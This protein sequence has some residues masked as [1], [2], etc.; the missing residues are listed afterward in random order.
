[1]R[2]MMMTINLRF[3]RERI[4]YRSNVIRVYVIVVM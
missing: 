3:Q 2:K 1:M 4:C